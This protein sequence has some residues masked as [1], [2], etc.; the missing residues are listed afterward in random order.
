MPFGDTLSHECDIFHRKKKCSGKVTD[1]FRLA[2]GFRT[3]HREEVM[4]SRDL[5]SAARHVSRTLEGRVSQGTWK[6][7]CK[8][9]ESNE[10][11]GFQSQ[12]NGL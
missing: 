2:G 4:L 12:E 3:R 6:S 8:D 10:F 7:K 9:P 11:G 5:N 1:A